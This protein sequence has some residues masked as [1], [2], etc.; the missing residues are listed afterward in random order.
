MRKLLFFLIVILLFSGCTKMAP[1]LTDDSIV[2]FEVTETTSTP[3][4]ASENTTASNSEN[5]TQSSKD[6]GAFNDI[7]EK[8][9]LEKFAS[10][11]FHIVSGNYCRNVTHDDVLYTEMFVT[12]KKNFVRVANND[13]EQ[14]VFAYNY[15]SDDFTYL[16]YY[17][18]ELMSKTIFNLTTGAIFEDSEEYAK[19]LKTEAEEIKIYF[20]DLLKASGLDLDDLNNL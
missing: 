17:D 10:I 6:S 11:D 8:E 7:D 5:T 1:E 16:Y 4:L 13:V 19:L 9:I 2:T 12:T 15:V 20:N 18:G 14:E 3:N